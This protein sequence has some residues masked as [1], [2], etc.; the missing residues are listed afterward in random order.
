MADN[1]IRLPSSMGGLINYSQEYRSKIEFKPGLVIIICALV[2]MLVL[3][4][5]IYGNALL[6]I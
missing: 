2:A 1:K 6:G 5:H 4:M 3:L